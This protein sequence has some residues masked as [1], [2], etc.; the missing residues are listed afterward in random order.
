[1]EIVANPLDWTTVDEENLAKFLETET[2]KRFLPKLLDSVPPLLETGKTKQLLIRSGIVIGYQRVARDIL[3]LAHPVAR[4]DEQN[5]QSS[6]YPDLRNDEA[7]NDGL[8][9]SPEPKSETGE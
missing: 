6:A 2:G 5:E 7:W 3:L 1:M 8:K 4:P 9:L